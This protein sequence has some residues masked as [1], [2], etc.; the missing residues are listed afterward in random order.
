MEKRKTLED[1][2]IE[3]IL[4][5]EDDLSDV[6]DLSEIVIEADEVYTE[7][8]DALTWQ[9]EEEEEDHAVPPEEEEDEDGD[10]FGAS[11]VESS[12]PLT[13]SEIRSRK[14]RRG[15]LRPAEG[16][17]L[18]EM[19]LPMYKAKDKTVWHSK[20]NPTMPPIIRSDNLVEGAPTTQTLLAKTTDEV[21]GLFL[22]DH[23]HMFYNATKGG[24]DTFDQTC[25]SISCSRKTRRWPLCIFFGILNIVINNAYVL[26]RYNP[27]NSKV[28]RRQFATELA[29]QLGRPFAL[30]R[31]HNKRYLPRDVT[32]LICSVFEVQDIT[33]TPGS[34]SKMEKKQRCHLC[35][36]S[37]N[38][39]TKIACSQCQKCSCP[40]HS[41]YICHKCTVSVIECFIYC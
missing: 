14:R 37:S 12:V 35:P 18:L 16:E 29:M 6:E 5:S 40:S 38:T 2:E 15:P 3:H 10:D 24:V 8:H 1:S 20:L 36:S 19:P 23:M 11:H 13:P 39:R 17:K 9:Q 25:A 22:T 33:A 32:S 21:F 31:L 26:Y 30:Q 7:L 4:F 34:S 41:T 28:S 27:E